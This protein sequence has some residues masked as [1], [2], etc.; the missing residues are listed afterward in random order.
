[1]DKN[2]VITSQLDGDSP[3]YPVSYDNDVSSEKKGTVDD[4][5][6]MFRM[7]KFQEMRV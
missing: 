4:Q 2:V 5:R 7:G 3:E 6:D 1:M